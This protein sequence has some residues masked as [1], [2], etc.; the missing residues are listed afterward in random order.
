MKTKR[1]LESARMTCV[2]KSLYIIGV[3]IGILSA[4]TSCDKNAHEGENG[5]TVSLSMPNKDAV[6]DIRLWVYQSDGAPIDEYHYATAGELSSTLLPL[7]A[8]D[9]VLI[10][11][12]NLVSPFS[13][14]MAVGSGVRPYE[15]LT[16]R[17]DD[18]S[19]SP[20]H[21]HYGTQ[22]VKVS[23]DGTTHAEVAMSR[24]LA[25]LQ[26]T[27]KGVPANVV[28]AEAKVVNTAK[29]FLPYNG[30]LIP[31]TDIA[32]LGSAVPE[33]GVISFPLKRLMPVVSEQTR[34][35]GGESTKTLLQFTFH[36]ADGSAITFN[37]EAPAMENGG[38]YTP[39]VVFDL[40]RP[41][42][43]VTITEINGWIKGETTEGEIL[44]PNKE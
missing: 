21:A 7:P 39:E 4:L 15:G 20:A 42:I 9:Y 17:L 6:S 2:I 24:I 25:E 37:A 13:P 40:F 26:F 36:Y 29:A 1:L 5:L 44:N 23:G 28:K 11:A 41:G 30:Q 16:F 3:T 31:Y 14:D 43:T 10:T 33:K 27:V 8:G 19:A 32:D 38:T 22:A 34:A 18:A 12:T 35:D